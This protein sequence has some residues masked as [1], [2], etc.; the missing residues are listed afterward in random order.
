[1]LSKITEERCSTEHYPGWINVGS[2]SLHVVVYGTFRGGESITKWE[3]DTLLKVLHNLV[4]ESPAKREVYTKLTGSDIFPLPL[5]GHRWLKNKRVAERA[6]QIWPQI[7]AYISETLKQ[8]S[9]IPTSKTF[10]AVRSAV[11]VS[12]I[13]ARLEFFVSVAVI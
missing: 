6:L 1:M 9:H 7:I 8:K 13:T 2:C 10:S 11:Q 4:D 12:L 3:I 5:C